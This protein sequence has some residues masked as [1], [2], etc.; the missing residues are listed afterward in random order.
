MLPATAHAD[1]LWATRS[2]Q[3]REIGDCSLCC[4]GVS[5]ADFGAPTAAIP[6][7]TN[8]LTKREREVLSL[9]AQGLTD[10]GISENL[11]LTPKTVETHVRH[12]LAKLDLPNGAQ[13]NRRVLAVL[14]YLQENTSGL[15]TTQR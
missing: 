5:R 12:I 2:L 14:T 7:R 8:E 13:H 4:D 6:R 15:A 9:L 11:W 10:R 3:R 1:D